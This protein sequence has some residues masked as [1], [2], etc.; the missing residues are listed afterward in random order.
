MRKFAG[1]LAGLLVPAF[2]VAG[3]TATPTAAYG[4][5]KMK[6]AGGKPMVKEIEKNDKVRVFETTYKPGDESSSVERPPRAVRALKG[7]TLTRIYPDGKKE[8][9]TYKNGEVKV[10]G[11]TPAYVV[12]NESKRSIHLYVCAALA[13][14]NRVANPDGGVRAQCLHD[15]RGAHDDDG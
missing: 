13:S 5:A 10:F 1:V 3:V 6:E 11:A 9:V 4:M 12:K 2:I 7:G 8:K 15:E 14:P